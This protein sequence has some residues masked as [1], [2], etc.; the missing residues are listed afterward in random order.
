MEEPQVMHTATVKAT[1]TRRCQS[2]SDAQR[3]ARALFPDNGDFVHT[4]V[5][6]RELTIQVEGRSAREVQR[7]LDDLLACL[8]AAEKSLAIGPIHKS[9]P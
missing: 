6:G 7:S 8:S 9:P 1:L 5:K 2:E 4:S 3:L